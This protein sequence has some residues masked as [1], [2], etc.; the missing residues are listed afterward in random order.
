VKNKLAITIIYLPIFLILGC[1]YGN[2]DS[3]PSNSMIK[4][5]NVIMAKNA[6]TAAM[7]EALKAHPVPLT[8]IAVINN[9]APVNQGKVGLPIR[10]PQLKSSS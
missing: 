4:S 6:A 10:S 9:G 3:Q 1:K 2:T 8:P 5:E 7:D